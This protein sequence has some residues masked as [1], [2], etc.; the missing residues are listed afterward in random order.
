MASVL[1]FITDITNYYDQIFAFMT[2][3]IDFMTT[4]KKCMTTPHMTHEKKSM[5]NVLEFTTDITIFMIKYLH[6]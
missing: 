6:S 2:N 3:F 5:A 4:T 1:E